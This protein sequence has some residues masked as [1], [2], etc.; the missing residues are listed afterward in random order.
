MDYIHSQTN[1]NYQLGR[2][3]TSDGKKYDIAV[4][5]NWPTNDDYEKATDIIG[6]NLVDFYFCD[7][8]DQVTA[9]YVESYINKQKQF[10]KLVQK[11]TELKKPLFVES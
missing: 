5:L 7:Y 6:P 3:V 1:T 9:Q 2:L 4:I 11:L 10:N 8:D